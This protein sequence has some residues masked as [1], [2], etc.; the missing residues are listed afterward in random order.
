MKNYHYKI[1]PKCLKSFIK[2]DIRA[3]DIAKACSMTR[4]AVSQ[5]IKGTGI[6]DYGKRNQKREAIIKYGKKGFTVKEMEE[7]VGATVPTIRKHL[8]SVGVVACR[9]EKRKL[10]SLLFFRNRGYSGVEIAKEMNL[11]GIDCSICH[12]RKMLIDYGKPAV[13]GRSMSSVGNTKIFKEYK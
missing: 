10:A 2:D 12:A 11:A 13:D 7:M 8:R 4:Q 6:D 1:S 5:R 3:V 9:P